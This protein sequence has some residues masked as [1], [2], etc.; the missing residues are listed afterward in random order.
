MI[1]LFVIGTSKNNKKKFDVLF[2][3][4]IEFS[5][6]NKANNREENAMESANDIGDSKQETN[7]NELKQEKNDQSGFIK[8]LFDEK[9]SKAKT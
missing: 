5:E 8:D 3:T 2:G 6:K 9:V 4:V 1:L 7:K